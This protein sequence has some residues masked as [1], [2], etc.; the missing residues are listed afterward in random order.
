[1]NHHLENFIF[2]LCLSLWVW[3]VHEH[4]S[5]DAIERRLDKEREADKKKARAHL[6]LIINNNLQ[7]IENLKKFKENKNNES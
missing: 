3:Y 5:Y 7:Y 2:M 4:W 6:K 1:M